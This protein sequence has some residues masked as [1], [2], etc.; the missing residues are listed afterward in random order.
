MYNTPQGIRV[1]EGAERRLFVESLAMI[2]DNLTV[3]DL[4]FEITVFDDLQKTQKIAVFH[5]IARALLCK[6]ESPPRLTA[7]LEA[8]VSIVYE[9]VRDMLFQEME[10]G[11][12][13]PIEGF[14]GQLPTWRERVLAACGELQLADDLPACD[15][16]DC[17][18]WDLLV[19]CLEDCVLWDTDFEMQE[20]LDADPDASR[21]VKGE[22][23][24]DDDYFVAVPPDPTDEEAERLLLDLQMLTGEAR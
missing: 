15:S 22:L 7:T 3:G 1:L 14:E 18:E 5:S 4:D 11:M 10:P 21:R 2:V 16:E 13:E 20:H 6:A 23:G 9:H 12:D 8:A 24:I 17:D 19:S